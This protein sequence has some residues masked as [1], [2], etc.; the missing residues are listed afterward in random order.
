MMFDLEKF[1]NHDLQFNRCWRYGGDWA[2]SLQAMKVGEV[3]N[4]PEVVMHYRI[5]DNQV[6]TGMVDTIESES[7]YIRRNALVWLG[8][9]FSKAE[10]KT[11][12]A[13]SPC[14]YW[15]FGSHPYFKD[16]GQDILVYAEAWFHKLTKANQK[17]KRI[18][19]NVLNNVLQILYNKIHNNINCS[20]DENRGNWYCPVTEHT[21]CV[22]KVPCR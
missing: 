13:V 22:S 19:P 10:L 21:S 8:V 5:H 12:L 1:R 17:S 18:E 14:N 11:H 9:E 2:I 3:A 7:A 16:N 15:S 6:T 20:N 4:I